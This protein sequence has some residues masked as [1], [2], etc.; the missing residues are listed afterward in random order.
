VAEGRCAVQQVLEDLQNFATEKLC[1]RCLP[2]LLATQNARAL[3]ERLRDGKAIGGEVHLLREICRRVLQTARCKYGRGIFDTLISLLEKRERDF[4]AHEQARCPA[5]ACVALLQYHIRP[6]KCT[7]C[8]RC[9][10]VCPAGAV[11]GE[12]VAPYRAA[13]RPYEIVS[14]KCNRCGLCVAACEEKA[15]IAASA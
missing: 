10:Q 13:C 12:P 5:G 15:I 6:D 9:R 14:V 8:D 2:C 3:L 1:A 4:L 11:K 7:L